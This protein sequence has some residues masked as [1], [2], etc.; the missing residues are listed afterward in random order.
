M[1]IY[2]GESPEET[3]D[4]AHAETT[5]FLQINQTQQHD[6]VMELT[7]AFRYVNVQ[8]DGNVSRNGVSMLYEQ[9]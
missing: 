9:T 2:Y 8:F 6:S 4:T 3:R 1:N 5:D 7:K